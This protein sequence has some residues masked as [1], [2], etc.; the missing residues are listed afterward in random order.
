MGDSC[1]FFLWTLHAYFFFLLGSA[2][3]HIFAHTL[4]GVPC[5]KKMYYY[6]LKEP[7]K[8]MGER[9]GSL[10]NGGFDTGFFYLGLGVPF[11]NFEVAIKVA[12]QSVFICEDDHMLYYW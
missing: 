8:G 9:S 2:T 12:S 7:N 10:G 6:K 3:T 11:L 4:L 1:V 5:A